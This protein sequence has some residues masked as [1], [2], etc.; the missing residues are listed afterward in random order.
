M[1]TTAAARTTDAIRLSAS[2]KPRRAKLVAAVRIARTVAARGVGDDLARRRLVVP[3]V[4]RT[5]RIGNVF[6]VTDNQHTI[7]LGQR[8]GGHGAEI[9]AE[10][11][12]RRAGGVDYAVVV[13]RLGHL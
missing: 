12:C 10:L 4:I 7:E 3:A 2:V 8:V 5:G 9:R 13:R 6:A 1:P 11:E